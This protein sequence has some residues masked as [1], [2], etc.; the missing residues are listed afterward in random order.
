MTVYDS[1]V[2]IAYLE[3]STS[4]VEYVEAHA[5]RRAVAPPLVVYELYQGEVFKS[6]PAEFDAVDAALGWLTVVEETRSMARAA[7]ELQNELHQHGQALTARDAF[8][9]GTATAL[10]ETLAV[11]DTDFD[12]PGIEEALDIDFVETG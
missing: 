10:G 2:L 8:I 11:A 1:S 3:G 9:A 6:G 12:V 7:A 5:D 4:A